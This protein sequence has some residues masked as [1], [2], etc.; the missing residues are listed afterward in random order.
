[1]ADNRSQWTPLRIAT[2]VLAVLALVIA[3]VVVWVV[4]QRLPGASAAEAMER[5]KIVIGYEILVLIFFFGLMVLLYMGFG[6]IDLSQ[7]LC[8]PKGA[9][10]CAA[11]MSRFQLLIFTFVIA[12]SLFLIIVA[13][14]ATSF[15]TIPSEVLLLLGISASTYA[16]GKGIQASGGGNG[17]AAQGDHKPPTPPTPPNPP[18]PLTPPPPPHAGG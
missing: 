4:I 2:A 9:T 18:P 14:G 15:P 10:D 6:E 3:L 13:N 11:S 12:M 8:E 5:L 16:V 7:L 1:M 17:A